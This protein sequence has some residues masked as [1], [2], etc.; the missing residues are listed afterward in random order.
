[1]NMSIGRIDFGSNTLA[2]WGIP[3]EDDQFDP[4]IA[5]AT[6]GLCLRRTT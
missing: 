6:T 3:V 1:M 4:I 2:I 5:D